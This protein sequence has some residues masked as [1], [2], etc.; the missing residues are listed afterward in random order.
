MEGRERR[1][2]EWKGGE[3]REGEEWRGREWRD[4]RVAEARGGD[5]IRLTGAEIRAMWYLISRRQ[6]LM[7]V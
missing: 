1:G 6:H 7:C 4:D 2:V 3:G 5:V